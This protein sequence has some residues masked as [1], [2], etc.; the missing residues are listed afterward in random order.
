MLDKMERKM[1]RFA[2]KHLTNYLIGGYIIGYFLYFG[3]SYTSLDIL[4]YAQLEPYFIIHNFQIWR[5][6]SWV[7]MPPRENIIF[8]IIMMIFYWQLGTQLERTM[9]TF[10]YS[11]YIFGGILFTI[12]GA[13][14]LYGI[15]FA[16]HGVPVMGIG[17]YFS[18][19][20]INM[21]IFLAFAVCYPDMEILLYFFIPIK[22]KWMAI[23]YAVLLV[24]EFIQV[25]MG[26]KVALVAS[27]LN[28]FIFFLSTRNWRRIDPREKK[29]QADW[30]R[31]YEGSSRNSGDRAYGDNPY[32]GGG[33]G[34]FNPF[35][36]AQS[37]RHS[38]QGAPR[39]HKCEICGRTE[40]TNPELTFRYCSKCKGNH[41]YCND[42]LFT[43]KHIV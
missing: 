19:Y 23:V 25:D 11:V 9:G 42:H 36:G 35:G 13:F 1:G 38:G 37:A 34:G 30:K 20:Y 2:V 27:L 21:S 22:M 40:I 31:A 3:A 14:L 6:I 29:R 12:I 28:F 7:I 32:T 5:L 16:I 24:F 26:G 18:T 8:A 4:S 15:Y 17:A 41:E 43:H 39:V 33:S 10:R